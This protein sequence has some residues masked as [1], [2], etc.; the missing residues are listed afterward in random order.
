MEMMEKRR[1][2]TH[3]Y[4]A[5]S[6]RSP[7]DK[8]QMRQRKESKWRSANVHQTA[9]NAFIEFRTR[10]ETNSK[11]SQKSRNDA[12]A[13]MSVARSSDDVRSCVLASL[14]PADRSMNFDVCAIS[15]VHA[16]MTCV[17]SGL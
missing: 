15:R 11:A 17:R 6:Y 5:R 7:N 16:G 14:R 9:Q 1:K 8:I 13:R 4:L 2:P 10:Y 12:V 3:L